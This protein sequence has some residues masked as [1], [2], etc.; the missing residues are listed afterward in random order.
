MISG[1]SE[2]NRKLLDALAR[3]QKGPFS[4]HEASKVLGIPRNKI[5][6]ILAYLVRKGWLSRVKRGL[7]ISVPLGTINPQEYKEHPW[8]VANHVFDPCYVGGWSAAE[9]WGLTDQIFNSVVVFTLRKFKNS[10]MNIQGTDFVIKRVGEKNFGVAKAAWIENIKVSVSDPL[11]TIVDILDDPSIGGG[12]RH[13]T[14]VIQE[15]FKSQYRNDDE[16]IKYID[17]KNNRTVFK[18]LGFLIESIG[19]DAV[20]LKETCEKKISAGFSLLDPAIEARGHF[21]SKWNLRINVGMDK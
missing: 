21:N 14:D 1:I 3:S 15:Y 6:I 12:M 8:V 11:Q 18:R 5:R 16:I 17:R 13:V 7:Y 2:T 9:H 10:S 4:I 19:I 20:K